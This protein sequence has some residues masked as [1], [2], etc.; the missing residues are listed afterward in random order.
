MRVVNNPK[1]RIICS[2]SAELEFDNSDI[3]HGGDSF[4]HEKEEYI[5]C[6]NCK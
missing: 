1:R 6:P 3:I 5:I 4:R 2:C